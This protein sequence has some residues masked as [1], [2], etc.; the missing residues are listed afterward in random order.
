MKKHKNSISDV[1]DVLK[2][3]NYSQSENVKKQFNEHDEWIL[4]LTFYQYNGLPDKNAYSFVKAI[5]TEG[6]EYQRPQ[7][8]IIFSQELN[9]DNYLNK[10]EQ[11]CQ[12]KG[13]DINYSDEN[14]DKLV[15]FNK[16]VLDK[17]MK[18]LNFSFLDNSQLEKFERTHTDKTIAYASVKK[19]TLS[20]CG[21]FV[22]EITKKLD[23]IMLYKDQSSTTEFVSPKEF[24]E[25]NIM[26]FKNFE[27]TLSRKL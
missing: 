19:I 13:Y 17:F 3:L 20:E 10:R 25:S 12:E 5:I 23:S 1:I 26:K 8:L 7:F 15:C 16:Y 21:K 2:H 4:I 27:N 9:D 18:N 11:Y 14:F 24:F 22:T 6:L